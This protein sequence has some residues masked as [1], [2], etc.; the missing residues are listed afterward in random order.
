MGWHEMGEDAIT[1]KAGKWW[2]ESCVYAS[3]LVEHAYN[4]RPAALQV[5]ACIWWDESIEQLNRLYINFNL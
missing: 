1:P 5:H 3:R 4:K 2:D